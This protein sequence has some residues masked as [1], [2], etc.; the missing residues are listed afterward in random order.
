MQLE[1]LKNSKNSLKY[2]YTLGTSFANWHGMS[3]QSVTF[4]IEKTHQIWKIMTVAER[5]QDIPQCSSPPGTH[6]FVNS[7]P[8]ESGCDLWLDSNE[9]KVMGCHFC[10]YVTQDHNCHHSSHPSPLLAL[11]KQAEMWWAAQ[12]VKEL[13]RTSQLINYTS[14]KIILVVILEFTIYIIY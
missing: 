8:F 4:P 12:F 13:R 2:W 7:L 10:N 6:S 3:P 1:W 11:V 5:F 9:Y 14:L